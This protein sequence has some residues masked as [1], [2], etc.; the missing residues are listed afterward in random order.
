MAKGQSEEAL[1][2]LRRQMKRNPIPAI[3]QKKILVHFLTDDPD[4]TL[5][6]VQSS[7]QTM[8]PMDPSFND[9]M[10][11]KTILTKYYETD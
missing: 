9:L 3:E 7:F 11:L 1:G 10:E 6:I 8:S 2:F 4:S 5:K